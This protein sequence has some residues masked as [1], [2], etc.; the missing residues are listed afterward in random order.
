MLPNLSKMT[1][2]ERYKWFTARDKLN[3]ERRESSESLRLEIARLAEEIDAGGA[4]TCHTCSFIAKRL[5]ISRV[6]VWR[7][8]RA[9]KRKEL[10]S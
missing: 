10:E 3:R 5:D 6:T 9:L 2:E 1:P 4:P 8:V 7:H